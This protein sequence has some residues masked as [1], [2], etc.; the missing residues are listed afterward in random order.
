[1]V[2][3]NSSKFSINS[4]VSRKLLH[5]DAIRFGDKKIHVTEWNMDT[6]ILRSTEDFSINSV[7]KII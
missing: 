3:I 5:S 1:M 6:Q 4:S 2:K 7:L